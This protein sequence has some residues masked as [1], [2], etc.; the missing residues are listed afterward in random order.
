MTSRR[1]TVCSAAAVAGGHIEWSAF[2]V[3]SRPH[4]EGDRHDW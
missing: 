3:E 1:I 4:K 2:G